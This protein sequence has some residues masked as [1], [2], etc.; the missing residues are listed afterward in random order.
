MKKIGKGILKLD[1]A[2]RL[3]AESLDDFVFYNHT[4]NGYTG[5]SRRSWYEEVKHIIHFRLPTCVNAM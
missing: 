5:R 2:V 3:Y 4:S 1:D